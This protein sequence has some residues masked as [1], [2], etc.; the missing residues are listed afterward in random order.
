MRQRAKLES[1]TDS[2]RPID[3]MQLSLGGNEENG[4]ALLIAVA[5]AVL[6][7]ENEAIPKDF[8]AGLF[9]HVAAEDLVLY[10]GREIAVLAELAWAYLGE[11]TPGV[12]KLRIATPEVAGSER[13]KHVSVIEIVNDDAPFLFDSVMGE[14][15]ERG[16]EVRL[17]AHP[18]FTVTRD[19][20][21]RL[22]GFHGLR[23]HAP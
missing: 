10:D 9:D 20:A 14:L 21:G 16:I 3:T 4:T 18:V 6:R 5:D 12:P 17:V 23:A 11:R 2:R 22:T 7:R 15:S 1:S 8:A 19:E 13:L